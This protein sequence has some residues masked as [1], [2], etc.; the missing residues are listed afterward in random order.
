MKVGDR[1]KMKAYVDSAGKHHPE[2]CGLIVQSI[3]RVGGSAW[4]ARIRAI[5]SDGHYIEAR[6]DDF[7]HD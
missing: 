5:R 7:V 4:H 6:Q 2:I 3:K 1:V